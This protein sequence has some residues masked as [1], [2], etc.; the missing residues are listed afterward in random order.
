LT[1]NLA[2]RSVD[3]DRQAQALDRHGITERGS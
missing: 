3:L 2:R 1:D